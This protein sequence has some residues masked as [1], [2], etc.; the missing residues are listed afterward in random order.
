MAHDIARIIREVRDNGGWPWELA[1]QE[2]YTG[3]DGPNGLR[4]ALA[5]EGLVSRHTPNYPGMFPGFEGGKWYI[6]PLTRE[7]ARKWQLSDRI[8][9]YLPSGLLVR[10]EFGYMMPDGRLMVSNGNCEIHWKDGKY[11]V[12]LGG[13]AAIGALAE[14]YVHDGH[15][16]LSFCRGVVEERT[17]PIAE[18]RAKCRALAMSDGEYELAIGEG[19]PEGSPLLETEVARKARAKLA[20]LEVA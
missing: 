3:L 15:G 10:E 9:D 6:W 16:C 2:G 18:Y 1:I 12:D 19:I 7:A 4:A 14:G 13:V 20:G 8:E 5:K 17:V 11:A